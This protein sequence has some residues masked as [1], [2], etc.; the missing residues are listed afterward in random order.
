MNVYALDENPA[1]AARYHCDQHISKMLLEA[2]QVLS[3]VV[4]ER[5][6]REVHTISSY[7]DE[8]HGRKQRVWTWHGVRIYGPASS[9]WVDWAMEQQAN[10]EWLIRLAHEL[11]EE[12][13]SRFGH[14]AYAV[15]EVVRNITV[16]LEFLQ[17]PRANRS[18]FPMVLPAR[19]AALG[20]SPVQSYRLHY[21][22]TKRAIAK[23]RNTPPPPWWVDA[24]NHADTLNV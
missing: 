21:A 5:A 24:M 13:L 6:K 2:A 9:P 15:N 23:W 20:L 22:S 18:T 14:P 11:N 4:H 3:G 1:F 16:R 10:T 12:T 8:S 7:L 17:L 19:I